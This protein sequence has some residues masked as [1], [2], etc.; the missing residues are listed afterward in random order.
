MKDNWGILFLFFSLRE[1]L[2][3]STIVV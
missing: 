1:G 2:T 3:F